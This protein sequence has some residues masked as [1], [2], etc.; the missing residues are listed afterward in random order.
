MTRSKLSAG[1]KLR[2]FRELAG[3]TLESVALE[4]G[5]AEST[6]RALEHNAK[7][8]GLLLCWCYM[9]WV[10]AA[11]RRRRIKAADRPTYADLVDV[12]LAAS[13]RQRNLAAR[14]GVR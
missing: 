11:G 14:M 12:A 5:C 10:N 6:I 2:Y 1:A 4:V 8:G 13:Q 7:A 3:Q 9:R